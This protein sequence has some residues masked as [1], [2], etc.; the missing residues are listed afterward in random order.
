MASDRERYAP[1]GGCTALV[2]LILLDRIY[3]ANAGDSRA[4]LYDGYKTVKM[5]ND[6]SPCYDKKRILTV[7]QER[8]QLLSKLPYFRL[9]LV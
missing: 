8:P 2:L 6:F 9:G 5:S 1:A 4:I 3:V 7:V